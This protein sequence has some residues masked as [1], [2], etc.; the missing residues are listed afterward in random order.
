MAYQAWSVVA[1]W[2]KCY[3]SQDTLKINY[4]NIITFTFSRNF[5]LY[6]LFHFQ[7]FWGSGP[8]VMCYQCNSVHCCSSLLHCWVSLTVFNIFIIIYFHTSM[9]RVIKS[10]PCVQWQIQGRIYLKKGRNYTEIKWLKLLIYRY[11]S[12]CG[13]KLLINILYSLS[14]VF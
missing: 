8:T 9:V 6:K 1:W 13:Q 12:R 2:A 7:V 14:L 11:C 10:H 4:K 3:L 5:I